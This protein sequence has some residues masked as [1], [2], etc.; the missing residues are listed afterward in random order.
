M[1]L[2]GE[3]LRLLRPEVEFYKHQGEGVEFIAKAGNVLLADEMGL[4]KSLQALA[5][6]AIDHQ[7]GIAKRTLVVTLATLKGNWAEEITR[8]T[9]F[10]YEVLKNS[11][12]LQRSRQLAD[13]AEEILIVNYEQVLTCWEQLNQIG[14]QVVIYDEAHTIKNRSSKRTKACLKL[15][16]LRHILVTGSPLL[17]HVDDLWTLL[18]RIDPQNHPNYWKFRA[19]YCVFGGFKGKQIIGV[20]NEAELYRKLDRLMLRRKK[21]EVLDL[22]EKQFVQVWVD[23]SPQQRKLY[24]QAIDEQQLTSPTMAEP[25]AIENALVRFLRLKE[26][27]GSAG[28]IEGHDDISSKLD[29]V[30][31]IVQEIVDNAEPVVIFTQ[32]RA[33]QYFLMER[34]NDAGIPAWELNGDTPFADRVPRINYWTEAS[35]RGEYGALV[36]MFQVGGVGLNLT[37]ASKVVLVDKLFVPMLNDQAID[38]VHRIGVNLTRPV[39]ILEVLC[40]KTIEQRIEKILERKKRVF[41]AVVEGDD[42]AWKAELVEAV[43]SER[44]D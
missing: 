32:F 29:R 44:D 3:P 43:L 7:R 30:V 28:T 19:R 6:A 12:P 33:I 15:D 10:T 20:K 9:T 38:R 41:G 36:A 23:L 39:Q 25:M 11:S 34:I 5:V 24:N 26:I 18:Y 22:P 31:E 13:F 37:A 16:G 1:K 4:G 40:R 14:F 8:H 21:S 17:N 27:C 42:S 2:N 35:Q